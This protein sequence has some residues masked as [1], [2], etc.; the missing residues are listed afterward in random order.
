MHVRQLDNITGVILVGGKSRR[1]GKDKAFLDVCGKP[2]FERVLEVFR[3]SFAQTILVGNRDERFAG[4]GLQIVPDIYP[5][6]AL[7]GLYAGLRHAATDYVFVAPC[8][9]IFPNVKLLRHIC[10][11]KD[12]FN[13]V[14]PKSA[15]GFEPLYALYDKNCLEPIRGMLEQGNPRITSLYPQIL[16][17]FLC[18]EE[19]E[20]FDKDGKSFFNIN[21][22]EEF[23]RARKECGE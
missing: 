3:E 16:V 14:V 5:G 17:R 6:S 7:G 1:M 8:D 22:P 18:G 23:V 15:Y 9:M 12:G 21:T 13:A 20:F 19:L 10:S 2:L 4:Y 11:L